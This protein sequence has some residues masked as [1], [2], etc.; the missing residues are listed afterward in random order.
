MLAMKKKGFG[1]GKFNGVGGKLKDGET[2]EKALIRETRE[3]IG[4]VPTKYDKAAVFDFIFLQKREWDQRVHIYLAREWEGEP[5]ESEEMKPEWF[6]ENEIPF[7]KMWEDDRHW[8]P[9][10]LAGKKLRGTFDFGG[11]NGDKL[12]KYHM[13]EFSKWE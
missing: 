4:V 2:V 9:L 10:V 3:E 12:E 13:E 11:E 6:G 5:A 8:L 1:A 7:D